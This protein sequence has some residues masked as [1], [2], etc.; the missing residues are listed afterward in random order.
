VSRLEAGTLTL[1]LAP[2]SPRELLAEVLAARQ[3]AATARHIRLLTEIDGE[4]PEVRA[5]RDRLQRVLHELIGYALGFAGPGER[6]TVSAAA[7]GAGVTF[8]V[9]SSADYAC[10]LPG[11]FDGDWHADGNGVGLA[12][13]RG[14]I[15]AHGGRIVVESAS[16][17]AVVVP[18][19][20]TVE[21]TG[22]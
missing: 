9:S 14:L 21:A 2:V 15:E 17:L 3:P 10:E 19:A 8:R 13:A 5:D 22:G 4:L 7:A 18:E 6:I 12:I 16:S 1:A 20:P 11:L